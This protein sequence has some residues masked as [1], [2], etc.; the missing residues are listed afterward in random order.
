MKKLLFTILVAIMGLNFSQAQCSNTL[1]LSTPTNW[2]ATGSPTVTTTTTTFYTHTNWMQ[3]NSPSGRTIY[4]FKRVFYVGVPGTYKINVKAMG[5]NYLKLY[6]DGT[7]GTLLVN[8]D[9]NDASGFNTPTSVEKTLTLTC[10]PHELTATIGDD[11]DGNAGFYVDATLTGV[12]IG[13]SGTDGCLSNTEIKCCD[14]GSWKGII[15]NTSKVEPVLSANEE[16]KIIPK[17]I[18]KCGQTLVVKAGK[19]INFAPLYYP[20]S[21]NCKTTFT[22]TL[23]LPNGST[24]N[25]ASFAYTFN[26]SAPGYYTLTIIPSVNGK[27]CP[28]CRIRIFVTPGCDG[29]IIDQKDFIEANEAT[30]GRG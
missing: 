24:Q 30:Q 12:G 9:I 29:D 18:L 1:N 19:S 5:N 22:G 6:V 28:P 17:S 16:N 25:I 8:K 15:F 21:P 10:G 7:S 11:G 14:C 26:Q 27:T 3:L 23:T 20:S 4:Q 2:V 13:S